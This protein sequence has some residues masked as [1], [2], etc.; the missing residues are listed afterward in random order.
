MLSPLVVAES[1]GVK[2]Y[3]SLMG[4]VGFPFT[5]GSHMIGPLAAGAIYDLTASYA[6]AFE[7]CAMIAIAGVVAS[8]LCVYGRVGAASD[9]RSRPRCRDYRG[10]RAPSQPPALQFHR[11]SRRRSDVATGAVLVAYELTRGP[12]AARCLFFTDPRGAAL[13]SRAFASFGPP[14]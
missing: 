5:P 3:G 2:R 12:F 11:P 7:L 14:N 10:R 9:G 4:L 1:L 6:R 13:V 8:F